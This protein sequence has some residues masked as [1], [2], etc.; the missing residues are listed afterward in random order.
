MKLKNDSTDLELFDYVNEL[1][2]QGMFL[3]VEDKKLKYRIKKELYNE[4]VINEIKVNKE[5]LLRY[6]SKAQENTLELSS[7][8]LAYMAGQVDGEFL[9]KVNAHYYIEFEKQN[10][11]IANL[12]KNINLMIRKND[13][14]RL[15][16]LSDGRGI[17]LEKVPE[18]KVFKYEYNSKEDRYKMRKILS[19]MKYNIETWPMFKFVVGKKING[20]NKNDVLHISFDC[21][22][23]DAWSAGNMIYKLF[24]LYEGEKISFSDVSYK[25]YVMNLRIYKELAFNKRLLDEAEKYWNKMIKTLPKTPNLRTKMPINDLEEYNFKR[26]E[27]RFS[28]EQTDNL[29]HYSKLRGVTL[30]AILITI[31]MKVLSDLIET[32]ELTITTTLFGKLPVVKNADELLGEFTNIGLISYK[33][34]YKSILESIKKTQK[35]IF[36]LL[37]YRCFDGIN[38]INKARQENGIN[39]LFPIV[40]TCMIGESYNNCKNGFHEICSLSQTPQVYLDHHIRMIDDSIVITFDYIDELL[41][42]EDIIWMVGKYIDVSNEICSNF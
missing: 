16:L 26:K 37:E 18:Y 33:D 17:I 21:S 40:V 13:I 34:E 27:Y 42:E 25:D 39:K 32:D 6:L 10:L 28:K 41:Y 3:F 19:H 8:Q 5:D 12:E 35:Q 14:L 20:G 23:L 7:L 22:I 31:Y 2:K 1:R 9:N 36:K 24:A 15:I 4:E 30:S 38:V 29:I 11:N